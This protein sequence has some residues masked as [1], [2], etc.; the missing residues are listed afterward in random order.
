MRYFIEIAYKGTDFHGWQKQPN[1]SSV[2]HE[3]QQ[4]LYKVFGE[5]IEISGAGRTD[6]GVHAKQIFAHFD[7]TILFDKKDFTYR[8]NSM[9]PHTILIKNIYKVLDETHARFDATHRSYEYH[10]HLDHNP[11][12]LDTTWQLYNREFD[13]SKMNQAADILLKYTN[14][15]AFSKSRT[16][17]KTY[18]C[19]ISKAEWILSGNDL[20]F[21]ITANRFLRNMVRAIVG[22]LLE[23]GEEK[24]SIDDFEKIILSQDR[25]KAGLSVPAQGLF[26]T[27][28]GY[29]FFSSKDA[30]N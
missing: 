28:V 8:I 1:A 10:I 13:V 27:E 26:L 17:V 20:T 24:L 4:A 21:Y 18:D 3:I 25:S 30:K 12:L 14:F 7:T 15:K 16:D 5:E 9:I 29:A 22:T 6:A 11:F 19:T 23:V 2:Q